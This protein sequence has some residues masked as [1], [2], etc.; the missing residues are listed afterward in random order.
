MA[1]INSKNAVDGDVLILTELAKHL[2]IRKSKLPELI[3]I[4]KWGGLAIET[5]FEQ[6]ISKVA[7]V[8]RSNKNG[9]D[10]VNGWEAKKCTVSF[11]TH[12]KKKSINREATV[13]N[14]HAKHGDVL[15]IV[16]DPLVNQLFYFKVPKHEIKD[17]KSITITLNTSGGELVNFRKV[18]GSLENSFSWRL[19]N[20]YRCKNFRDLCK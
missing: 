11:H 5:F 19:W 15:I 13:G 10:F 17:R 14:L 2:R 6:A 3:K 1:S 20:R 12:G 8:A 9:E 7:K 18:N 4:A 16:A